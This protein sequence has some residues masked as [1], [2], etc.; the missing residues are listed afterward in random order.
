M[1]Y[2]QSYEP[3][4]MLEESLYTPLSRNRRKRKIVFM[5]TNLM[6]HTL[7]IKKTII[8]F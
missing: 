1:S 3:R 2:N 5:P 7:Y 8:N 4:F 6:L